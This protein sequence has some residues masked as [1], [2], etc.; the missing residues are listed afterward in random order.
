MFNISDEGILA[1][2]LVKTPSVRELPS[3][4]PNNCLLPQSVQVESAL[5]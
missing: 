3:P 2:P 5:A 1:K 4:I